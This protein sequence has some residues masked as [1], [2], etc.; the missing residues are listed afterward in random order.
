MANTMLLHARLN[1]K[2]FYYA[3]KYAEKVHDV[4]PVKDLF[5]DRGLPTTP[6]LEFLDAQQFLRSMNL[7]IKE[8]G[9]RINSHSKV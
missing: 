9:Q 1:K 8:K 5:D 4:I 3:A 2:F 6:H 7:V